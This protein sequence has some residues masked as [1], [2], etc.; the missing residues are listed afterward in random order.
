MPIQVPADARDPAYKTAIL[1]AVTNGD[2]VA[3]DFVQVASTYK[4][5][6]AEFLCFQDA[7]KIDGVRWGMGAEIM[8]P[9]A[10]MLGCSFDTAKIRDL[11]Y[12]QRG[13]TLTPVTYSD[14]LVQWPQNTTETALMRKAS[15]AIDTYLA[16]AGGL[17]GILATVGKPW[18]IINQLENHP[19]MTCNY[20]W[21]VPQTSSNWEGV[22][23]YPPESDPKLP[24]RVIQQPGEAHNLTQSDYAQTCLLT[25]RTCTV[26]GKPWDLLDLLQDPVLSYLASHEGPM[27]VLRQP[28]VPV[29][30]CVNPAKPTMTLATDP[31]GSSYCPTPPAP[32]NVVDE[33][34]L[35]GVDWSAVAVTG[36]LAAGTIAAFWA[37]LHAMGRTRR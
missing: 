2:S 10:D 7:L 5:H 34:S 24:F 37:G 13:R 29:F 23:V 36:L 19:G 11:R 4:G 1:N 12:M 26:D 28:G 9:I 15:A 8:Q 27:R 16:K 22:T 21:E 3:Y 30:A 6:T 18:I 35:S 14:P 32:T 31:L 25:H 17:N 33:G 20:G